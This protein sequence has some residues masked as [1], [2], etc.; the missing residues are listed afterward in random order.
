MSLWK[1]FLKRSFDIFF[2]GTVLLLTWPILLIVSI[3]I[4]STS[5]GPIIFKQKRVGRHGRIFDLC[6]FRTMYLVKDSDSTVTVRGDKRITP[7]GTHLRRWKLD[8]LPQFWNVLKGDMSVV[9]PRPDVPGYADKLTRDDRVILTVRPG[10]TGPAT[11]KYR[12]EEEILAKQ[13]NPE[14]YNDEVIFPDKVKI[15]REYIQNYSFWRD[16]QY[17]WQTMF[18]R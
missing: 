6:K 10:I 5:E 18:G 14:R 4:K 15:N 9:G 11:L 17:I 16:L 12:N 7:L 2:S 13:P 3:A 1:R 8:E